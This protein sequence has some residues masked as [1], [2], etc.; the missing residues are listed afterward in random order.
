MADEQTKAPLEDFIK[1]LENSDE[2]TGRKLVAKF[3][4]NIRNERK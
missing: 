1:A 4:N 2:E 3:E